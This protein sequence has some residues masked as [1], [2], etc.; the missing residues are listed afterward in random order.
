MVGKIKI[1]EFKTWEAFENPRFTLMFEETA[2]EELWRKRSY[3]ELSS[4]IG[5]GDVTIELDSS[6]LSVSSQQRESYA[7][8]FLD[9][10]RALGVEYK[11]LKSAPGSNPSFWEGMLGKKTKQAFDI[12]AYIP[13]ETWSKAEMENSLS[14]YG[15]K[16]F[17]TKDESDRTKVLDDFQKM[18]DDEKLNYFKL[19]V[20]DV[21]SFNRM[22]IYTNYLALSDIKAI[23]GIA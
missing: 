14:L 20:F 16:Y 6:L 23:L 4:L 10:I 18:L 15:A 12:I 21:P 3:D 17:I 7:L 11:C 13:N 1:K 8:K 2:S 22:G 9:D 19:V 5:S